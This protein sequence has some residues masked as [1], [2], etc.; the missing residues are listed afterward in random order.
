[1]NCSPT[2]RDN[3]LAR[4]FDQFRFYL[5]YATIFLAF[6]AQEANPQNRTAV[7]ISPSDLARQ[8]LER[9]AASAV[10]IES[11]LHKDA[12]LMVELKRWVAKDATDHGQLVSD[13]DLTDQAIYDRLEVDLQF[14]SV[15]TELVQK[16]GYLLPQINPD[17]P[18][19][20][21][22]ELVIQDRAKWI[23]QEAELELSQAR[24]QRSL[25]LQQTRDCDT[26]QDADCR[27][28]TRPRAEEEATEEIG[29]PVLPSRRAPIDKLDLPGLLPRNSPGLEQARL[30]RQETEDASG[31]GATSPGNSSDAVAALVRS[32]SQAGP[33]TLVPSSSGNRELSGSLQQLGAGGTL[34]N[35]A[36]LSS[37]AASGSLPM[38]DTGELEAGGNEELPEEA[39]NLLGGAA[40]RRGYERESNLPMSRQQYRSRRNPS[41]SQALVRQPVPYV[42]VPSLYDMYLQAAPQPPKPERF[43]TEVFENGSRDSQLIPFDLPAGPDYVVGPGDGLAIDLWG[44]V[45]QRLRRTVD[46]EG[47]VSLPEVGPLLVAGKSLAEVQQAVQKVL[48]SQFRDISA[49][50][51]LSRLRTI[52]VYVVGD[53]ARPGAYDIRSLSTPLNALFAAGGPTTQGSLRI[54]RH[55]RG[56]QPVQN[57]DVYDLLLHGV[58]TDIQRLE[59]GDTI[60]VPSIGP[61]VTVEGMVRRPAIYEMRD[62]K[63]LS[64]VLTL[65]GGLLPTA[66]LRHIEVQRVVAHDKRTMMSLDVQPETDPA[67]IAKQLDSFQIQDGDKIRVFPIAP[68]NQDTLYL[69]GHVLRPG[70]YTFRPGMRVTDLI[71][72]YK[73]L[74]PEPATR[75]AEIIRLNPPDYRPTVESFNLEDAL[76]H[77]GSAP[78]LQALD[79]V[80]VFGRYDFEDAPTILVGGDVRVPGTYRTSGQLRLGDAIQM[81]GGL[82]PDAQKEDA[83]VFRYLPDGQLKIFSVKLDEALA[84][85]PTENIVLNSRDRILVHRNSADVDPATVYIKGEV[86]RPGRYPLTT[87]M[88]VADLIRAAGGTKQS[89]DPKNADLMHYEWADQSRLSGL[90]EEIKLADA[91]A[92]SNNANVS[93]HNGD[94]LT[95]R[96]LPG[97]DD[98]GASIAVRGEVLHPGTYGIRPGEKLSSILKRAGGFT[99]EAYSYGAVL[100]RPQVQ[101]IE[102][103]SRA[104]LVERVRSQGASLR[105]A[106]RTEQDPDNR[107][108]Q[109]A[110]YRQWESTLEDLT[111][112]RPVGRVV[113]HISNNFKSWEGTARDVAVRAG[114]KLLIP[115]RPGYVM[116]QGQVFNPTAVAFRSEK[117]AKWYLSQAGGPTNLANKK[118]IFVIRADGSVSGSRGSSLFSGSALG[119]SL[120]PGDTVVVPEKALG[121]PPIWKAIFQGV[122][123]ASSVTT[124]AIFAAKY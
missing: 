17:S 24:Q 57:V 12:G 96:Q 112:N 7:Q 3:P 32:L 102:D 58:R 123:V 94:V 100:I 22:Q 6:F 113:I 42:A 64:D 25:S 38:M 18:Q 122:Q 117:S 49:D 114:D 110:A 2:E 16:Y 54:L 73:D 78:L 23:A 116:V 87:N 52:R 99:P 124:A 66:T 55:N 74:L 41:L 75:Y 109:E 48:R 56:N 95:I 89:A 37:L 14:R 82:A 85:N 121:G 20:K 51:S 68:Y 62:E 21:E 70:K 11:V 31:I 103:K 61:E 27:A 35:A 108:A 72:S 77:P 46:R 47:R 91:L 76:N 101:Q 104:E 83:Q 118:T 59:N 53:V 8:N 26:K 30:G 105:L 43:G 93:L 33:G 29:T 65:A 107:L 97:W 10:Q 86:A 15:A 9:V 40:G 111:N 44:G 67:S 115:K 84:G 45:S 71:S 39:G 69:E 90:R 36:L 1:M 120:E 34:A 50:V 28:R 92:G 60:L 119:E 88:T 79:T 63:S 4:K 5:L 13:T 80:Q 106:A 19:G 81:A 98:L